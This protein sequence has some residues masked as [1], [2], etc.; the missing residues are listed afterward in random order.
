MAKYS[1]K[2]AILY[3]L[4]LLADIVGVSKATAQT[5][6]NKQWLSPVKTHEDV[7]Q[8]NLYD[9]RKVPGVKFP[10]EFLSVKNV[11]SVVPLRRYKGIE[12][13]AGG[14]G[15]ALGMEKAGI[16]HVLLNEMDKTACQTLRN[17]RPQW[18]I[19][20]GDISKIDFKPY[21]RKVD[22][23]SGG[24][25]CQ[26]F[27]YSGKQLGFNDVRGTL[28]FEYARAVKEIEPAI[29][30]AENVRGLETHDQG[31][32]LKTI[33]GII[34]DIGYVLVEHEVLKAIFYQVPQKRERLILIGVRKDLADK[35][36]CFSYPQKSPHVFTVK[37]A[38]KKGV[39]YNCD[40]KPS[41][42][43]VYPARKKFIMSQVPQGGY[44]RNLPDDLQRE[45]MK[46]SYFLTG[47]KTGIARRLSWSMPSL[48]LTTSPAQKQT[49]R[50]HP[51]EDRP[52]QV[53]EYARIQT[54]PDD[55]IFSGAM[56]SQYRQ[57]GN[58]VPVNLAYAVSKEVVKFLNATL[59]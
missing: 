55:W 20:E 7:E 27:S 5:W 29:F 56:T 47:G 59:K 45:Y 26:A 19:V 17:N 33:Q 8:F 52:L 53:N 9:L 48:T 24:F 12:V 10:D 44:W 18:N 21:H 42:G 49:E 22:V 57:I 38:L 25:P 54:F 31:R 1:H 50:C 23:L 46:K 2:D 6:V 40:V 28:F 11:D 13:F 51:D 41:N 4:A 37:D 32:T 35:I 15:L 14:G 58:A 3:P 43:Q 34:D 36:G 39:L 30:V 16:E